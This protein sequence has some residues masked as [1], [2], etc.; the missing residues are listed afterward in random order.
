[1]AENLLDQTPE[2]PL[3]GAPFRKRILSIDV[4]KGIAMLMVV[5]VHYNQSF[6]AAHI[7]LFEFCQ[8]GCQLFFVASGFG[9]AVS[10]TKK[11]QKSTP[12]EAAKDF[13]ISRI[14][15]IAPAWWFMMAV[16][17]IVNTIVIRSTGQTLNFGSNRSLS[18][19]L[20][21][22]LFLHGLNP[23]CI[24]S[25]M[26]GGWYIGTAM[27]L[28][29]LAPLVFP[30]MRKSP[31]KTA[32]VSSVIS[33]LGLL[34]LARAAYGVDPEFIYF[35]TANN[36]FGFFSFLT[37][38]PSF[39]MGMLLYFRSSALQRNSRIAVFSAGCLLMVCAVLLYFNPFF[40]FSYALCASL[41]GL[42]AFFILKALIS[43]EKSGK[44]F[45]GPVNRLLV[46]FGKNSLFIYLVHAFFAYPFVS[47]MQK[48][49]SSVG[50]NGDSRVVF[51]ALF[52]VVLFLSC[53]AGILLKRL[54]NRVVSRI[55]DT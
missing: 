13:Y 31:L 7:A 19:Q 12:G 4:L 36:S 52:P 33:L 40:L 20:C 38:Y 5:M 23:S 17:Y 43:A 42:S 55:W 54:T 47:D 28:Y 8:M 45:T 53:F 14:K 46:L 37:Q 30:F 11:L 15:A 9:V 16:V 25:V 1:M 26:P 35:A 2:N 32:V 3:P 44:S 29:A 51:L 27:V 41:V 22:V 10:L 49:L 48:V 39:C 21:N 24:N 18:G 50:V 34:A 6:H